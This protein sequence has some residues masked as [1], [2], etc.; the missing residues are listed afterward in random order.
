MNKFLEA[1]GV[2]AALGVEIPKSKEGDGGLRGAATIKKQP[3][4]I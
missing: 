3:S 4:W 2:M 1:A